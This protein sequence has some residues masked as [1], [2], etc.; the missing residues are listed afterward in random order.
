[1]RLYHRPK[2]HAR[3]LGKLGRNRT[4]Q[5]AA[6][7]RRIGFT[8][9]PNRFK[10]LCRPYAPMRATAAFREDLPSD[11]PVRVYTEKLPLCRFGGISKGN[12]PY[13]SLAPDE[14]GGIL[15]LSGG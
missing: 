9:S 14:H 1:M 10:R 11:T 5:P 13:E 4:R 7:L 3:S 15:R 8:L 6:A 12:M 2:P